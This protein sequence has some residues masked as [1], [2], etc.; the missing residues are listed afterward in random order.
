MV[1]RPS[2]A[3]SGR[4]TPRPPRGQTSASARRPRSRPTRTPTPSTCCRPPSPARSRTTWRAGRSGARISST[5]SRPRPSTS[6]PPPPATGSNDATWA[7]ARPA[8][9]RDR[10]RSRWPAGS[11]S[12]PDYLS[13]SG[14]GV[15]SFELAEKNVMPFVGG[16]YGHDLVG[17]TGDPMNVWQAA[18]QGQ[19]EARRDLRRQPLDHRV[20]CR[21]TRSW[22]AATWPSP[23]DTSPSSP[24][25]WASQVPAGASIDL[26]KS[27]NEY[28]V[29]ENVP[30]RTQ[31]LRAGGPA[32][33]IVRRSRPFAATSGSTTTAGA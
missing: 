20:A 19:P 15:I 7:R 9:R 32:G 8:S 22:N 25:A 17:R 26:V 11:L 6:S 31:S 4:R 12:E 13:L 33:R 18:E 28:S 1:R 2:K 16:S 3:A 24:R 14:G 5:R 30:T 23:I 21:S 27:L 10:P 29:A